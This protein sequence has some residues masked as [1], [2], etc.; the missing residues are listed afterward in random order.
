MEVRKLQQ[1]E[2][3]LLIIPEVHP[4]ERGYFCF[5]S[6]TSLVPAA[7]FSQYCTSHSLQG[8]TRGLHMTRGRGAAKLV[9][10][11]SGE[12]YDVI[13]DLR[14]KSPTYRNWVSQ[15]LSGKTCASVYIPAGCAHGYQVTSGPADITYRIDGPYNP[16][17]ELIIACDDPDLAIDWPLPLSFRSPQDK[18]AP[19]LADAE[20]IL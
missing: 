5:A 9:R 18:A 11:T 1:V 10:C 15:Q 20:R 4:D 13:V 16:A 19:S 14:L 2:G 12:V 6:D 7:P 3:A 8:V 17:N